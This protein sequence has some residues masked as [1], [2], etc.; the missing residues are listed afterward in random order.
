MRE[1]AWLH[2]AP[3]DHDSKKTTRLSI[4]AI[5]VKIT[6]GTDVIPAYCEEHDGPKEVVTLKKSSTYVT[7]PLVL[8][9]EEVRSIHGDPLPANYVDPSVE[10]FLKMLKRPEAQQVI[11]LMMQAFT[12]APAAHSAEDPD[13]GTGGDGGG[14][15]HKH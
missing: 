10:E 9:S 5:T 11:A 7:E 4:S 8:E 12:G 1:A 2:R 15:G 14:S 6:T 3:M 13:D